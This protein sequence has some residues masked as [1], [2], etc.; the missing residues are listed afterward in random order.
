MDNLRHFR[1][2]DPQLYPIAE[3][4][5]TG[6]R[7]THAQGLVL[8]NTTDVLGL[9]RLARWVKEQHYG[10]TITYVINRQINPTNLCV[11]SCLFCDFAA[12]PNDVHAYE[13]TLEQILA[14]LDEQVRE[15]HIVGG[16]HPYWRYEQYLALIQAIH[17]TYPALQIK[18]WSA[19]EIDWFTR[20]T[21]RS[22]QDV[23]SDMQVAGV[24]A[25]TGGG[26]EVFSTRVRQILCKQKISAERW[27]EIHRIAHTIGLKSNATLLYGHIETLEERVDHLLRLR[28]L[29]DSAPGF[30]AFI[31]LPL[32]KGR[33]QIIARD[34]APME[35]LRMIAVSRLLLDNFAH[36]KAYWVMLGLSTATMALSFGADD[37]DGTVGLER[38]AHAALA[39][40]PVTLAQQT[41][42]AMIN[43]AGLNAQERD[44][45]HQQVSVKS[46]A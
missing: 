27:L 35:D 32:Q 17:Q 20:L 18:A 16:L 11:N 33:R 36:I 46:V 41:L 22:I 4:I 15:V 3:A 9:G 40:S 7:L 45:L 26:A 34:P 37:I 21:K 29:E 19:V 12:K 1:L 39:D 30:Q 38:I 6:Q 2:I 42:L 13:L 25:L 44:A 8:F 10:K 31:P 43:E 28:E 23:L 14:A 24:I 5:L